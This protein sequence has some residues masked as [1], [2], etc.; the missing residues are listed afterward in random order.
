MGGLIPGPL[1]GELVEL[2]GG[3]LAVVEVDD[4][5]AHM[6]DDTWRMIAESVPPN[7]ARAYARVLGLNGGELWGVLGWLPWCAAS[8]RWSGVGADPATAETLAQ[9]VADL[10]SA[11]VGVSAIEQAMAAVAHLHRAHGHR[12]HPDRVLANK[13][14]KSYRRGEGA[15]RVKRVAP[16]TLPLFR[17]M[18]ATCD[19]STVKG[20]RDAA[21]LTVGLAAMMRR[22]ELA[23][24]ELDHIAEDPRGLVLYVPSSK[25]DQEGRG[26]EVVIPRSRRGDSP[27]D[28]VKLV[29][30][31][32]EDLAAQGHHTGY[33]FR[34][35][36][37]GGTLRNRLDPAG[38]DVV[39]VVK[40][41]AQLAGLNADEFAGHSLRA[42]GA[43]SA[44]MANAP[45]PLIM[46][47]GRWKRPEQVLEYIRF[48]DRWTDN[49]A[50]A[51]NL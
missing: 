5:N 11:R 45:L 3:G 33:L 21:L 49:A 12:G 18:F 47:Q 34:S 8:G 29:A 13:V 20:R 39:R 9:W 38:K 44:H 37:K 23:A 10:V 24:I 31:V 6:S 32:R 14:L 7:T 25:T 15:H 43:T 42:G 41:R 16:I 46:R 35:V 27:T 2:D 30:A 48:H 19:R 51:L 50:A 26:D 4:P 36:D 28:P 22:S 40:A 1:V 17:G